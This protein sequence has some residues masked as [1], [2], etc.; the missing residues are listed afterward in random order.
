LRILATSREPLRITSEVAWPVAPL[1]VPGAPR[2]AAEPEELAR[3]PAVQLFVERARSAQPAFALTSGNAAAVAQICVR[4]DGL[5]LALELAAARIRVLTPEQVADRLDDMFRV[6]AA[7]SRTAPTRQ[8]TLGA[9]FDWSHALLSGAERALFRRTAAFSGGWTLE[10]AEAVCA[11]D[12]IAAAD[13]LDLLAHL[14]DRS[15]VVAEET[16]PGGGAMRYR[17]LEPTRQYALERLRESGEA[18]PVQHH[19]TTYFLGLATA[20]DE[21][22][23]GPWDLAWLA[24][25]DRDL[26][27]LRAV[28]RRSL[29]QRELEVYLL[30]CIRLARFWEVRG[31]LEE[32][33]RWLDE[34]L[35]GAAAVPVSLRMRSVGRATFLAAI[36]GAYERSGPLSGEW[37][38][39]AREVG[40]EAAV[41][42]AN[43]YRAYALMA[44]CDMDTAA[45]IIEESLAFFRTGEDKV[46][47]GANLRNLGWLLA[48]QGD[49][50]RARQLFDEVVPLAHAAG[51]PVQEANGLAGW[52]F[53]AYVDGDLH[54]ASQLARQAIALVQEIR[55]KRYMASF[56]DLLAVVA[57]A[58]GQVERAARLFGASERMLEDIQSQGINQPFLRDHERQVAAARSG[59]EAASFSA[60]WAEGRA[61]AMEAAVAYALAD[62][63]PPPTPDG[64]AALP[65]ERGPLSPRERE[66]VALV[67]CGLSNREIA[68]RLIITERTA[69]AHVEHILD[70]LGFASRTQIGVWAVQHGHVA[71]RPS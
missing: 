6:L 43:D 19:H 46:N 47:L 1:A 51:D 65:S 56:L 48:R 53:L 38:A 9:T 25:V 10:A 57:A 62:D 21:L 60:A 28:L 41:A 59:P 44:Q 36:S 69:G 33:R 52:S 31:Y 39:L 14:V 29:E 7:G 26:D 8:Q 20:G 61:L 23:R 64:E 71:P 67:A 35:A 49:L 18:G 37:L 34:G 27:N 30:L 63:E 55:H 70:K 2:V 58:Q 45:T 22:W 16:P 12:A 3:Y 24:R 68:A 50:H 4:L 40:D 13:V 66:V 17:L 32:G 54:A 42:E 5:P 11:G 15:L